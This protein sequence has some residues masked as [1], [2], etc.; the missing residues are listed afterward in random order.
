MDFLSSPQRPEVSAS[1]FFA[2]G[3]SVF[4]E[5]AKK[6]IFFCVSSSAD[7]EEKVM[8]QIRNLTIT[9]KKDLRNLIEDFS[10]VLRP[11]DKTVLIGEEGNGKS[12]LLKLI[13]EEQL[14]EEYVTWSGE[15]IRNGVRTGYLA[16]E[17]GQE[18]Q[19]CQV[20]EYFAENP[21][22]YDWTPK[23]LADLGR[24]FGFSLEFF[25]S[26]QQVATLSGGEKVKLQLARILM[27]RPDVLLLDEPSNDIDLE[28][29]E[30]M[31]DF[32]CQT[33]LPIL[34]IS[35]DEYL[36]E[37]TA[38]SV[39]HLEQTM[40]KTKPRWTVARVPYRTYMEERGHS[41]QRLEEQA[42]SEKREYEKQQE[43][44][45]RIQQ[46]VEYKQATITRQNPSGGRLL[47]KKMHA[48]K[49]QERRFEKQW[50]E[51]TEVPDTEDAIYL[52]LGRQIPMPKGKEVLDYELDQLTA[53]GKLLAEKIH[54][55]I[56]GPEK[57][58]I[59]G[60]NGVGKTTLLKQ[61][62]Q[63][64]LSRKDLHAA[65]MPQ[66]YGDL[67]PGEKTPLDFLQTKGDKEELTRIRTWLGSMKFTAE[68]MEH[69]IRELSGGQKAKL[70]FMKMSLEESDVLIL[71]EPTRNFSPMSN[72][73]IRRILADYQGA[74]LCVSHDRKFIEEVCTEVYELT[75]DGLKRSSLVGNE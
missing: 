5:R 54:L 62:A 47:K 10:F 48:V 73:V 18:A 75:R 36:M 74:I 21:L 13:H 17:M 45:R 31:E 30:W 28:T 60:K 53:D 3:K 15:I 41:L 9:H 11:G 42:R 72:P 71:D 7:K 14:V 40:R 49:A 38:N 70:F 39:I 2:Y 59:I 56:R 24:N 20:Y 12:T 34:Y 61:I 27:E 69:P 65:Y 55:R 1:V 19:N 33:S 4:S 57:V 32:I 51:R 46:S 50:E 52:R 43:K 25:Y 66:N 63:E 16:Q 6:Q 23:E 68:E 8:L 29:L 26:D 35:H 37:R 58:C 44:F 64:L 22:F 67:L